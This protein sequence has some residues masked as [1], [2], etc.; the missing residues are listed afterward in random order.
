MVK[1]YEELEQE[2]FEACGVI[3]KLVELIEE[4]KELL[5]K[6]MPLAALTREVKPKQEQ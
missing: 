3:L 6:M 5:N 1:S 4:A 2:N